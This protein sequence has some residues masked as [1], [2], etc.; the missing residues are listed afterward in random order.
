MCPELHEE[1]AGLRE[2]VSER[3]GELVPPEDVPPEQ[4]HK[5]IRYSLDAPGKRIR[6]LMTILTAT[7]LGAGVEDALDPACAIEM[8]HTASLIVDDMPFM[9][10]AEMRRGRQANHRVFGEDVATLAAF[11]LLSRAFGVLA[12]ARGLDDTQRADLVR[13]LSE[14]LAGEGVIV[15]QLHDLR[16]EERTPDPATLKRMYEQK[17]GMLFVA[18]S[19]AGARVARVPPEWIPPIRDFAMNMGILF[20][21]VDDLL[22]RFGTL[23]SIGKDVG[24]DDGKTTLVSVLGPEEAR[25]EAC[26]RLEAAERALDPLGPAGRPLDEMARSLLEPGMAATLRG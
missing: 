3:L 24:Q 12:G 25:A 7:R 21:I 15:G 18:S 19:E 20:Q 6:P 1:V 8:V 11:D 4:L 22:D 14:T 10:D 17:T 13:L 23:E 26:H 5:A 2:R 16:S 9:D